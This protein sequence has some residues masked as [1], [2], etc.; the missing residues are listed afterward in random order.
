MDA[1]NRQ[2]A[3]VSWSLEALDGTA[4]VRPCVDPM[5]FSHATESTRDCWHAGTL[6]R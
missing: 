3:Y 4:E 2:R 5:E 6:V 1:W